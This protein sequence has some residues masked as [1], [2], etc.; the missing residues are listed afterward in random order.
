MKLAT[1]PR[2][3]DE[4]GRDAARQHGW[5]HAYKVAKQCATEYIGKDNA[6]RNPHYKYWSDVVSWIEKNAPPRALENL[7][8]RTGNNER[9][10]LARHCSACQ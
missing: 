6:A 2:K 10:R 9:L 1:P 4:W 8:S 7:K 3:P 5:H